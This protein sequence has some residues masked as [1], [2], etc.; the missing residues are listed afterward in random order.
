MSKNNV[1]SVKEIKKPDLENLIILRNECD[2]FKKNLSKII[3]EK[4]DFENL[5]LLSSITYTSFSKIDEF[6]KQG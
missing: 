2:R 1:N 3:K 6:A 5:S 4:K